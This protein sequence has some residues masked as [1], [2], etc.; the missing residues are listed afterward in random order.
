MAGRRAAQMAPGGCFAGTYNVN[1]DNPLMTLTQQTQLCGATAGTA[2]L[3]SLTVAKRNVEG[4]PRQSDIRH[5]SYRIV[6]GVKG[7]LNENWT[8]DAYLQYSSLQSSETWHCHFLPPNI[9]N[10]LNPRTH[11]SRQI[12]R[13]FFL[14]GTI[15]RCS[16]V[17]L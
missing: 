7:D 10:A 1:C 2:T 3:K 14:P 6:T 4:G 17:L 8:Y 13:H 16:P 12:L 5:T 11:P 9:R 15:P